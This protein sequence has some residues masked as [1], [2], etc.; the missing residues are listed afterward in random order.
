MEQQHEIFKTKTSELELLFNSELKRAKVDATFSRQAHH[1]PRP[2][3]LVFATSTS[4]LA[5]S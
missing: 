4:P 3:R 5:L 2:L 1:R